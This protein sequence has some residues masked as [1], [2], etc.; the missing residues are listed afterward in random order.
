MDVIHTLSLRKFAKCEYLQ[1]S[2][3]N[4]ASAQHRVK[5][6]KKE[7]LKVGLS[8]IMSWRT[9]PQSESEATRYH[10]CL[11]CCIHSERGRRHGYTNDTAENR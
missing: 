3:Q 11:D 10:N 2:I 7:D 6:A 5:K 4:P 8:T 1:Y 9:H